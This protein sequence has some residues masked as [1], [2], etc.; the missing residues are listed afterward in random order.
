M[1]TGSMRRVL[2]VTPMSVGSKRTSGT[3]PNTVT[4]IRPGWELPLSFLTESIAG[5]RLAIIPESA[6]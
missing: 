1:P 4:S 3:L 2:M 5:A 6:R